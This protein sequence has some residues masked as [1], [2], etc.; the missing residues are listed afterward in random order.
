MKDFLRNLF[1][2]DHAIWA[3]SFVASVLAFMVAS[4]THLIPAEHVAQVQE[5]AA[6]LAFISGKFGNSPLPGR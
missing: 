1:T 4:T 5:L 2:R 6:V 3:I